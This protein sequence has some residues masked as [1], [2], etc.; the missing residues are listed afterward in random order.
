VAVRHGGFGLPAATPKVVTLS[1]STSASFVV[2]TGTA[3]RCVP[4][5]T[6]VIGLPGSGT[7]LRASTTMTVCA[8][9]AGVS[10][11]GRRSDSETG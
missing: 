7:A 6:V 8:G 5:A 4:T 3:G 10:P 1:R 2:A 9:Q 11:V